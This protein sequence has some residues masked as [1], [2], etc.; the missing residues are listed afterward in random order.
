MS[1]PESM[2]QL[3]KF[4]KNLSSTTEKEQ[5]SISNSAANLGAVVEIL[6]LVSTI[7]T[8][9]EQEIVDVSYIGLD[10]MS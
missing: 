3:P 6:N 7:P 2:Q 1:S 9:A 4:L 5:R 8:A 10:P